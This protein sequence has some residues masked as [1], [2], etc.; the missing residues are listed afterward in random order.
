M[1]EE[2]ITGLSLAEIKDRFAIRD[3]LKK[4]VRV[5]LPLGKR[6]RMSAANSHPEWGCGNGIQFQILGKLDPDWF[7]EPEDYQP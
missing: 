2:D 4:I 3:E 5:E 6:L 1:R 7:P